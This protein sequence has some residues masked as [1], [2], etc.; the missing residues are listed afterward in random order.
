MESLGKKSNLLHLVAV[1]RRKGELKPL[2]TFSD[3]YGQQTKHYV[4]T[5]DY[6]LY[7][8][9]AKLFPKLANN[10][11]H[12]RF[13]KAIT[14]VF[15]VTEQQKN[16]IFMRG[17]GFVIEFDL[18]AILYLIGNKLHREDGPAYVFGDFEVWCY[19]GKLHRSPD[20]INGI[21]LPA[22][23]NNSNEPSYIYA[24][25][26]NYHRTE[27]PALM[28]TDDDRKEWFINGVRHRIDG[29][30]IEC[31]ERT[32]YY[33][34]G[35]LHRVDGPAH[36]TETVE[37][38]W[39]RGKQ[40]RI[41]GPAIREMHTYYGNRT[42][43][44]E[45]W[46]IHG[47]YHRIG[48]PAIIRSSQYTYEEKWYEYGVVHRT[49][50]GPASVE[51]RYDHV[52]LK[53][54]ENGL[55]HRKDGPAIITYDIDTLEH[56]WYEYGVQHRKG[57]PAVIEYDEKTGKVLAETWYKNGKY[58]RKDGPAFISYDITGKIVKRVYCLKG[59]TLLTWTQGENGNMDPQI[60]E[61]WFLDQQK[62][63]KRVIFHRNRDVNPPRYTDGRANYQYI[64]GVDISYDKV[65]NTKAFACIVVME[66][67]KSNNKTPKIAYQKCRQVHI[68]G[69]YVPGFLA[70]REVEHLV[71]LIEEIRMEP[72]FPD[73]I[74][75]DGNGRLHPNEF[76][77]AS[78][79]GVLLNVP[80]IGVA[81]D[82]HAVK[83]MNV[84]AIHAKYIDEC[85]QRGDHIDVCVPNTKKVLGIALMP[86]SNIKNPIFVSEGHMVSL[87]Y[88]KNLVLTTCVYR[89]PDPIRYAD[90]I[91]R[92]AIRN[93]KVPQP[94]KQ[95]RGKRKTK[96]I[97]EIVRNE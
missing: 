69:Y 55:N 14:V 78:H 32:S 77:L 70:Y 11:F 48:G 18:G 41:D 16:T 12:N 51:S 96:R 39:Y 91:S 87:D 10:P 85:K 47:K 72:Y 58:H 42:N 13:I 44:H 76:G 26:G 82:L 84:K 40:H 79:L 57:A 62:L 2:K 75:V 60:L 8:K 29:P 1:R 4:N 15:R 53:W 88:A 35:L 71:P 28:F 38:W 54:C 45:V 33:E 61:N 3:V 27:G 90:Q 30:A 7:L 49:D 5:Y 81:K 52:I 37:E 93:T 6:S 74:L 17:E 67:D 50:G 92:E 22:K 43:I 73:V 80:T 19:N 64:A 63:K 25:H 83:G 66:Y 97:R 68:T 31:G 36:K 86:Q 20:P 21:E 89:E 34:D 59:D 94:T 65:D 46:M 95:I 56:S 23:C 24:I 9:L